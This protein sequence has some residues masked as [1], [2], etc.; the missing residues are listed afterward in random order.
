MHILPL[1][2]ERTRAEQLG[3]M[4]SSTFDYLRYISQLLYEPAVRLSPIDSSNDVTYNEIL[5]KL[6][7]VAVIIR[8][9]ES[10]D[11]QSTNFQTTAYSGNR[12]RTK[13]HDFW[14]TTGVLYFKWV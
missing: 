7:Q 8:D 12:G 9:L 3:H 2:N 5:S 13:V 4:S 11:E 6:Q 1:I 14:G 10:T